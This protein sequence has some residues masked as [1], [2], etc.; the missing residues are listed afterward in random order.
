MKLDDPFITQTLFSDNSDWQHFPLQA[1]I[2]DEN[3]QLTNQLSVFDKVSGIY[4]FWWSGTK[5]DLKKLNRKILLQ[6]K[7]D[8]DTFHW[9][10]I[11]WQ[12]DWLVPVEIEKNE[13][14][15]ALY[16]GKSTTLRNRIRQHFHFSVDHESW[17]TNLDKPKNN[18]GKSKLTLRGM[19]KFHNEGYNI[20]YNPTTS[21]QFRAGMSLLCRDEANNNEFWNLIKKNMSLSILPC[22]D[23]E[24]ENKVAV[25]FY[26]EDYLIG[27]LRPWFNLD[28]E[29]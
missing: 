22:T 13:N 28:S 17:K 1:L 27:A 5:E 24:K 8:G 6:G 18:Q 10:P 3:N 9:H 12:M 19:R 26:L 29:R 23:T 15:Y 25:R 20:S 2:N 16:V 14:H 4:V 11:E 7:K 21:C